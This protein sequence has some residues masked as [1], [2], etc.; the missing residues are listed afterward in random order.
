MVPAFENVVSGLAVGDTNSL[1]SEPADCYGEWSE[2]MVVSMPKQARPGATLHPSMLALPLRAAAVPTPIPFASH[3]LLKRRAVAT[4]HAGGHR[5]GRAR[6]AQQ[7]R[8]RDHQGDH[9]H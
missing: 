7:R 8:V 5:G 2:Q 9:G 3:G 6:A 4:G 1:R